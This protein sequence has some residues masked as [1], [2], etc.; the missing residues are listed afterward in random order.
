MKKF[1]MFLLILFILIILGAVSAF[2]TY[3]SLI[4]APNSDNKK[5][6]ITINAG[7]NYSNIATTLKEKGLIKNELAYKVYIKLNTPTKSLEAGDYDI[8][9]SL[10]IE[11][12]IK[13]FEKGTKSH[14]KT[15]TVKFLEGKN[16]RYV[17]KT[18]TSNFDITEKE[19]L[20]KLKDTTYLDKLINDYW[21]LT[22][23]IKNKDIYYSLE[24]YLF[25]DTYEFYTDASLE[26]IFK[27]MLDNMDKKLEK[28]KDEVAKS[29]YSIHEMMTLASII[30]LE[31][32]TSNDRKSVAGVFYN[33][34][35]DGWSLGSD[36]TTYYAERIDNWTRD[37]K[38]SELSKCNK[39]NTRS[40]CM[41]GKLP[42]SPIC[43]PGINSIIAT[44]EP[45]KHNYYYFVA[46][47]NGKTY[48]SK[49]DYEHTST[50]SRLKREGLWIEYEN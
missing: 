40:N 44:I 12:L 38:A 32:G 31:A 14:A 37:L 41:N 1:L 29:K 19:I 45:K 10:S 48:F 11:D 27:K 46:D 50:V 24:G 36:V 23:S 21:F 35:K 6:S 47:K 42:V 9:N 33:R 43:N 4:K 28:Y 8:S 15:I 49:T 16:M 39:Y 18:I 30:E 20:A 34:L 3:K 22:K 26:D 17:I 25:P 2:F 5:I 13:E 7:D